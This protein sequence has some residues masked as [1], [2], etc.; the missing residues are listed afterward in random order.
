MSYIVPATPNRHEQSIKKSRFIAIAGYASSRHQMLEF[1]QRAASEYPDAGHVCYGCVTGPPLS[2]TFYCSD[3]GEPT[4]TAGRPIL[5][6]LQHSDI[7]DIVTVVVRYFGGVKL[8]TGGL[9]RAYSSSAAGAVADL[10]TRHLVAVAQLRVTAPYA[11]E[12]V[13]RHQLS[14]VDADDLNVIYGEDLSLSCKVRADE[15][16]A[17]IA[18]LAN[19][20]R[21]AIKTSL[22]PL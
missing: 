19:I 3:D 10:Q 22:T 17:L 4:G 14:L 11:M 8:G 12:N 6:V 21:G 18:T 15:A 2:G 5:N 1:I 7:G 9:I 13:I 16:D 20:S